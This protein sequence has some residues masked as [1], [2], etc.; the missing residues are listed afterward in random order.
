MVSFD[1]DSIIDSESLENSDSSGDYLFTETRKFLT[2][3][4]VHFFF[5]ISFFFLALVLRLFNCIFKRRH[6]PLN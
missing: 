2:L 4:Y 6:M 5:L 1:S 3:S